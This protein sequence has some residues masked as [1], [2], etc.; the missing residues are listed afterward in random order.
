LA[1][2]RSTLVAAVALLSA[3][4]RPRFFSGKRGHPFFQF[5]FFRRNK[6]TFLDSIEA[7]RASMQKSAT[8]IGLCLKTTPPAHIAFGTLHRIE[9]TLFDSAKQIEHI[10]SQVSPELRGKLENIDAE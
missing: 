7:L 5:P 3:R 6:M 2:R 10:L 4:D 9:R 1:P 8:H